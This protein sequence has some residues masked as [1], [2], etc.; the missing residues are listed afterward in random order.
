MKTTTLAALVVAV[1]TVTS[2]SLAQA[3]T[4]SFTTG[5]YEQQ[6]LIYQPLVPTPKTRAEVMKELQEFRANPVSADGQYRFVGGDRQWEPVLHSYDF[7]NGV[8]VHTDSIAHD[9]PRPS[10]VM[11]SAEKRAAEE[12][13]GRGG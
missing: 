9:T 2:V 1:T 12:L 11:T 7:R 6:G 4:P 8:L 3:D 10:V 5:A 13:Y